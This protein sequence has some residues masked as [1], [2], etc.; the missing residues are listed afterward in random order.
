MIC[1]FFRKR[2]LDGIIVIKLA[3][4]QKKIYLNALKAHILTRKNAFFLS[5]LSDWAAAAV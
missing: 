4:S 2:K 1:F 5:I 3:F